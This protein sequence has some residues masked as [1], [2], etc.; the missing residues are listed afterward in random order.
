M[1]SIRK[2]NKENEENKEIHNK[3]VLLAKAKAVK[4]SWILISKALIDPCISHNEFVLIDNEL[5]EYGKV[6]KN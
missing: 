3:I 5:K 2:E 6:K 1:K 4:Y